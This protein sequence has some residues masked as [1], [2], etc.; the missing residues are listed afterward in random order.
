M[1]KHTWK[2][3][4]WIRWGLCHQAGLHAHLAAS[5]N[6]CQ[7]QIKPFG[8]STHAGTCGLSMTSPHPCHVRKRRSTVDTPEKRLASPPPTVHRQRGKP[9]LG[10]GSPTHARQERTPGPSHPPGLAFMCRLT[11]FVN[12]RGPY[13][14]HG[15]AGQSGS[16]D[17]VRMVSQM[18]NWASKQQ[19][20][21]HL[22]LWLPR[23]HC[24]CLHDNVPERRI[25]VAAELLRM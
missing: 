1:H 20:L 25:A 16:C 6:S 13:L 19:D 18:L 3:K 11:L 7:I 4:L 24:P 21:G 22:G 5:R 10:D 14:P 2:W 8:P 15:N 12:G 23:P 17:S 9:T